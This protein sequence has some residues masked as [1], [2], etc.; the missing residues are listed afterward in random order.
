MKLLRSK[1]RVKFYEGKGDQNLNQ[2]QFPEGIL[3]LHRHQDVDSDAYPIAHVPVVAWSEVHPFG[4]NQSFAE[5]TA[6]VP[7]Q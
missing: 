4:W 3:V 5:V 7:P 6:I 2:W 1:S